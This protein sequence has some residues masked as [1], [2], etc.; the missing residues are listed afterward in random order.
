MADRTGKESKSLVAL[1]I[2]PAKLGTWL[3]GVWLFASILAAGLLLSPGLSGRVILMLIAGGFLLF[4]VARASIETR[5]NMP[6]SCA[7]L[8]SPGMRRVYWMGYA[9]ML[10]GNVLAVVAT[11]SRLG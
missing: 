11:L 5:P 10:S 6:S 4:C 8:L 2:S 1:P 3:W 9:L 7:S